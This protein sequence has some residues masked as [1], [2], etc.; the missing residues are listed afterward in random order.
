[1]KQIYLIFILILVNDAYT[2]KFTW[3][4]IDE[5]N[6][7]KTCEYWEVDGLGNYYFM[8]QQQIAKHNAKGLILYQMS[9]KKQ[10]EISQL[11]QINALKMIVFS[12][13]QQ[14][15]CILDNTLT[16]NG[17]CFPFENIGLQN[18][19]LLCNSNRPNLIWL[20]NEFNAG[21]HLFDFVNN[22]IIQSVTNLISIVGLENVQ[23]II[24]IESNLY[25][26]DSKGKVI[27]FDLFMN[28]KYS[29][30]ITG[31][32]IYK[33]EKTFCTLETSKLNIFTLS[34]EP[35]HTIDLPIESTDLVVI[36]N[37][38]YFQNK[39]KIINF[40]LKRD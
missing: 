18:V 40:E 21:L 7:P 34:G 14:Q 2:Q 37:Q 23:Q 3:V 4:K 10:G 19:K 16:T 9:S 33:G 31:N 32:F 26:L 30:N 12:E 13:M 29:F 15:I 24:E 17:N 8:E 25:V 39:N 20:Y 5:I 11:I 28:Q 36:S 22:K 35:L 1:M 6:L 27:V 38:Y